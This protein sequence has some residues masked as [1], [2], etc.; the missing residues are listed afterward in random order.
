MQCTSGEVAKEI[1]ENG[2]YSPSTIEHLKEFQC[3]VENTTRAKKVTLKVTDDTPMCEFKVLRGQA[4]SIEGIAR[5][6]VD[7]EVNSWS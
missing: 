3:R 5:E 2:L 4:M 1:D 7:M 6:N